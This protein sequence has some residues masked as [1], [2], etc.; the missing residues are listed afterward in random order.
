VLE[1][2]KEK[3]K[4]LRVQKSPG[5]NEQAGNDRKLKENPGVVAH[6]F[7]PNTQEAEAGRFLSLRIAWSTK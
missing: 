1:G 2:S 3:R 4:P 7:N 5:I 6:I